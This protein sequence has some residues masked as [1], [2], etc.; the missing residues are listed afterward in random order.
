[1]LYFNY[2]HGLLDQSLWDDLLASCCIGQCANKC[3]FTENK[4]IQCMNVVAAV[5]SATD[6]L[7]VYNI[8][9]PCEGGVQSPSW[10][11][12]NPG[13]SFRPV[14]ERQYLFNDNIFLKQTRK[15]QQYS[16]K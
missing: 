13:R 7:N 10:R 2:Y 11:V 4:S 16:K 15:M 9:A 8:Y 6:G 5:V 12:F 1:M 3:M 14:S